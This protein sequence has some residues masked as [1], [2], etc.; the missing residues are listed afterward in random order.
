[1]MRFGHELTNVRTKST[2]TDPVSEAD[3]AAEQAVRDVLAHLR[4]AD[5]ILGEEGGLTPV[6]EG[7]EPSGLM[8]I[9][10]PLDG[11]VNYLY[12]IPLF[13]VSIAVE[14]G[15]GVVAGVI[16]NPV[17]EE[18]FTATRSGTAMRSTP[19]SPETP[20]DARGERRLDFALVATGFGYDSG[21]RALQGQ[22]VAG[23]LPRVRDVRRAGAAA[24]DLCSVASGRV[25]AYYERGVKPWDIAAGVLLC[26]RVGL[27][28]R[29]LE[30]VPEG[31][32]SPSSA[33]LP[34]GIVVAPDEFMDELYT[35]VSGPSF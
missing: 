2:D 23:L 22:V 24:L 7:A 34:E 6:G 12:G 20:I 30:A 1:M 18:V 35:L 15:D 25:D 4:P 13:A 8:W 10:D 21:V 29:L 14:D 27:T 19:A 33:A 31:A 26:E 9:V 3:L 16:I 17:S 32:W 5:A 11:T 28:V